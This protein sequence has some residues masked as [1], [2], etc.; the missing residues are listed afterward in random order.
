[1]VHHRVPTLRRL[2]TRAALPRTLGQVFRGRC[3]PWPGTPTRVPSF[4]ARTGL[5]SAALRVSS[6]GSPRHK[7]ALPT[8][9]VRIPCTRQLQW[10]NVA[11]AHRGRE[12][13]LSQRC[14]ASAPKASPRGQPC[15]RRVT[16]RHHAYTAAVARVRPT[17]DVTGAPGLSRCFRA[18]LSAQVPARIR[19]SPDARL[20]LEPH[21]MASRRHELAV[22]EP[23]NV[24][25]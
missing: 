11:K 18:C 24:L 1:M 21:K 10:S 7:V 8:S 17:V 3:A 20:P 2:P 25:A 6:P 16:P 15:G 5:P 12:R 13:P 4:R 14:T 22:I 23:F 9:P 19:V